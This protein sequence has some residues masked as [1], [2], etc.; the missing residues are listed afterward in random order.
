MSRDK[1][2]NDLLQAVATYFVADIMPRLG[3]HNAVAVLNVYN[4][5]PSIKAKSDC[6]TASIMQIVDRH[7]VFEAPTQPTRECPQSPRNDGDHEWISQAQGNV[8]NNGSTIRT[9]CKNCGE[10]QQ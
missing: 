7:V 4:A 10:V 3:E 6:F 8:V 1:L 9:Y 5:N 2:A